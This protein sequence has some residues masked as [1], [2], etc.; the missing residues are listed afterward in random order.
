MLLFVAAVTLICGLFCGLA[1]LA[2]SSKASLANRD[3][4][5]GAFSRGLRTILVVGEIAL[6]VMLAVGA[7]LLI[8]TVAR[9]GDVD[10]GF[11][12]ANLLTVA[13]D[14]TTGPLRSRG[15]S[16]RF[17]EESLARMAALPGVRVAAA[18]TALPFEAGL[19]SQPI[20]REDRPPRASSD[21]PQVIQVAV[22]P[23]Y[24]EAM[25]MQLRAGRPLAETDR[26]DGKLV[27][28]LNETAARR[29][30]PGENPVG[31]RFAIGS[32]ER[33]GSFRQVAAGEVEW[34]EVVGIVSDIRSAGQSA[35]VEPEVYY[36]YRQYPVY[37]PTLLVRTDGDPLSLAGAV[38]R[39]IEAV[40][41]NA[42]VIQVRTMDAVAAQSIAGPG[43]RAAVAG[44][45]SLVAVAL[46]ML[47]VYGLMTYTVAQR[48]R[49]IA[50][51]MALGAQAAQV[52]AMVVRRALTLTAAGLLLGLALAIAVARWFSSL[53]FGVTAVDPLTLVGTCLLL[54]FAA[55]AASYAPA[56][57]ASRADPAMVLRSE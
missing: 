24:F 14:L 26:A 2:D 35:P 57:R 29:Y 56:R 7:G 1:P 50:I 8:R 4:T 10:M 33:F 41:R 28:I 51:R 20:T 27:A 47:G 15:N 44:G 36:C 12:T 11:R 25:G 32:L 53:L 18:T 3:R 43:L 5:E 55:V 37:G 48:T 38:R 16:A 30:W 6:A 21:S 46:G 54:A 39:E 52:S 9:L 34:R 23:R 19:A 13:T 45:F 31:K 17:L 22:T 40:D 42:V 49:E